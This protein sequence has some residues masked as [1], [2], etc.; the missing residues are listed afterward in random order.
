MLY[1]PYTCVLNSRESLYLA[2]V[3]FLYSLGRINYRQSKHKS[4]HAVAP[5]DYHPPPIHF[6]VA[7]LFDI[8]ILIIFLWYQNRD[9]LVEQNVSCSDWNGI[10]GTI[11]IF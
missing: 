3:L 1:T 6:I 7:V 11:M 2:V 4:A 8:S 10:W 9:Y 5:F